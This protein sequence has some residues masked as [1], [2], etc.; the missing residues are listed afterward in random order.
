MKTEIEKL[1]A[2]FWENYPHEI[3]WKELEEV[4][5]EIFCQLQNIGQVLVLNGKLKSAY[6]KS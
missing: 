2:F 5:P 1:E 3:T 6:L 4:N